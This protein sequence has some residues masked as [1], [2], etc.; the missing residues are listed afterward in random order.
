V[1]A[2]FKHLDC[3]VKQSC[4]QQLSDALLFL[5]CDLLE[6]ELDQVET[7]RPSARQ[8]EEMRVYS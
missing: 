6:S 1:D 5:F 2:L 7:D 4:S 8:L 3:P